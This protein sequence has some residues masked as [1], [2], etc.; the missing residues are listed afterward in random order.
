MRDEGIIIAR[1][2]D[3][4]H[5]SLGRVCRQF[6]QESHWPYHL[7]S[8]GS[9]AHRMLNDLLNACERTTC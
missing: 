3:D 1:I 4:L 6:R 7:S 9:I 5:A 8:G 2:E